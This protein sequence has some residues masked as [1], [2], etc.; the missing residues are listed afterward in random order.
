MTKKE[1]A[2]KIMRG[3]EDLLQVLSNVLNKKKIPF[4]VIGGLAV[5]AY[6][7]PVVSL[8]LDIVVQ[9]ERLPEFFNA[10][11]KKYRV[12]KFAN[13]INLSSPASDLRVQ[14]QT[15][16]RYQD[17]IS[18]ARQKDILGYK[19]PVASIEDVMQGKVWAAGDESP[20]PSKRQKDLADILRLVEK[21]KALIALIP[22]ELKS[23][24]L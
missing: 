17:F 8:D 5:N 11:G 4:C 15:D 23:R 20:R 22:P 19:L 2:R 13:S 24:L 1:F 12:K 21:K 9:S 16:A 6:A 14:V 18:R 7:E 10:L 3:R